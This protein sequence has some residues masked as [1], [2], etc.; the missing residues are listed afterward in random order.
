[1]IFVIIFGA[2]FLLSSINGQQNGVLRLAKI[3]ERINLAKNFMDYDSSVLLHPLNLLKE[4]KF[5]ADLSSRLSTDIPNLAL[6]ITSECEEDLVLIGIAA[7]INKNN[8]PPELANVLSQMIDAT[9]KI[10]PGI[11]RGPSNIFGFQQECDIINYKVP[12]RKREFTTAYSRVYISL[13]GD[14]QSAGTKIGF[15]ICMSSSC[16]STDLLNVVA[17]LPEINSTLPSNITDSICAISTFADINKPMTT[18]SWIMVAFLSTL[19]ILVIV[20]G[21]IDYC[22]LPSDT[23]LRK[24]FG[25]ELFLAFSGY[26]SVCEIMTAAKLKRGQIGPINC[27]RVMSMFWVIFGHVIAHAM[28]ST[29]NILDFM[30]ILKYFLTQIIENALFSV[31]TF[32]FIGGVLL[33]FMWFKG[34]E[35]DKKKL[36]SPLGWT[37]FYVHRIIRLSAP[38]WVTLLTYTYLYG[39]ITQNMTVFFTPQPVPYDP[40]KK[41]LWKNMLYIFNFNTADTCMGHTWYLATDMQM[42]VLTPIILIPLAL[43]P[44]AGWIVAITLLILSTA[45]NVITVYENNFPPTFTLFGT[46]GIGNDL[47]KAM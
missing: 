21:I 9:A 7:T 45:G 5:Y 36:M 17:I 23:P 31:D 39:P 6:N 44:F 22:I 27:L 24:E 3:P 46:D 35:R 13:S 43:Y 10:P 40:C 41:Y 14:C 30:P 29:N 1:M 12:N 19:A 4:H 37:M 15:D 20:S 18:G 33:A 26:K 2:F 32:F 8:T 28:T 38:Y 34:Y 25:V 42:F 47:T 11:S 16:T